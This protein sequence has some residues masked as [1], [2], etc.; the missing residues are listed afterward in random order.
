M[1]KEFYQYR[2]K[3][4]NSSYAYGSLLCFGFLNNKKNMIEAVNSN[5]YSLDI[6]DIESQK[7]IPFNPF[8]MI[9]NCHVMMDNMR[10]NGLLVEIVSDLWADWEFDDDGTPIVD[11]VTPV[12]KNE[13]RQPAWRP[14]YFYFNA[15]DKKYETDDGGTYDVWHNAFLSALVFYYE[16]KSA[17]YVR[18]FK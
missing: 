4:K 7:E 14:C 13:D 5:F 6:F 8:H 17:F 10:Y 18:G 11:T 1:K 15:S 3:R 9:Q 12:N 2:L 16:N